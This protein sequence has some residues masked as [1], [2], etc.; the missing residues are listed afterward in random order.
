MKHLITVLLWSALLS[1]CATSGKYE[2]ILNS[3]TGH[4]ANEL[5]EAWGYPSS[6]FQAPNG[7]TV[8]TY[9]SNASI[10]MPSQT[11]TTSNVIGNTVYSNSTTL[12]GQNVAL[13]CRTYF[14]VDAEQTIVKWS[15]EGNNCVSL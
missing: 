7:N 4:D 12:G 6:S 3:W 8:Y 9:D 11:N 10:K 13:W 2:E 14:E 1:S 5:V 15:F